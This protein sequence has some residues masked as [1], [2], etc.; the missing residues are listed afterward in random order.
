MAQDLGQLQSQIESEA[1]KAFRE[2]FQ[3]DNADGLF[4][5]SVDVTTAHE[6]NLRSLDDVESFLISTLHQATQR[7]AEETV[8]A[9]RVVIKS[10]NLNEILVPKSR[11]A[12]I[13]RG[14]R[15]VLEIHDEELERLTD[16]WLNQ[17]SEGSV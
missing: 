9:T 12:S 15:N 1:V 13:E 14:I 2:K 10:S 6:S 8:R 17:D 16:S 3:M 4:D 5:P 11:A 7:V